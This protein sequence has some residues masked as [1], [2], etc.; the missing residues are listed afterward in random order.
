MPDLSY[1]LAIACC[2]GLAALLALGCAR[3]QRRR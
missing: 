1:L 2:F 3:L